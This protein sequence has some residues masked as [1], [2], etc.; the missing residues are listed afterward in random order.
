MCGLDDPRQGS[1]AKGS[2]V[3]GARM[4]QSCHHEF[5][6]LVRRASPTGRYKLNQTLWHNSRCR[7]SY[8]SWRATVKN[9]HCRMKMEPKLAC[10]AVFDFALP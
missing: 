7:Y 4:R 5:R 6:R 9:R 10:I 2:Y 8:P 1:L 3:R